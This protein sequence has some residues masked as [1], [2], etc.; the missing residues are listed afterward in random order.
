MTHLPLSRILAATGLALSLAAP[1]LADELP[2]ATKKMLNDLKMSPDILSGLDKELAVPQEWID[3]AKKEGMVRISATWDPGQYTKMNAAFVERYPFIKHEYSRGSRQERTIK[4]LIAYQS[5]RITVDLIGGIGASYQLFKEAGALEPML[6]I[7][8]FNNVPVGMR[9]EGGY[10]V[11]QRLRYWCMSYNT[12]KVKK[13]DLP[14]T[15]DDLLTNPFW[16][17]GKLALSNRPN[18]W[19]AN[20]WAVDGYGDA[21]GKNYIKKLFEDVQPQLRKEGNNALQA[22]VIAGEFAAAVPAADYR[23]KQ[24]LDK[25]APIAWHCPEPVPFAISELSFLKGNPHPYASKLWVNWFLSKEGQMAQ[26]YAD[27][28]PPV[29][30]DLQTAEFMPFPDEIKDRKIAFRDPAMMEKF[31]PGIFDVW[32]PYWEKG[33]KGVAGKDDKDDE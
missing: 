26:Y 17:G 1:S 24:Y 20:V 22:L 19:L 4:P 33:A 27:Q 21:W 9:D 6:D 11:G 23:T 13:A 10:W 18:L 14:K 12:D 7:P 5:G 31:L 30:K 2:A 32:N 28:A 16:R 29:H 8:N 15:W 3:G 25:G